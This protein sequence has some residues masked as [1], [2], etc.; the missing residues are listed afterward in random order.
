MQSDMLKELPVYD[1]LVHVLCEECVMYH[2]PWAVLH[3]SEHMHMLCIIPWNAVYCELAEWLKRD[4][5]EILLHEVTLYWEPYI[6][7]HV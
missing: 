6:F 1:T 7:I 2:V 5:I 4:V 3:H